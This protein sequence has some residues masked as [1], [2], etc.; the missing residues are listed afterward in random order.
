MYICVR[1]PAAPEADHHRTM[2]RP[3]SSPE[4]AG[5][6]QISGANTPYQ[7]YANDLSKQYSDSLILFLT[8]IRLFIHFIEILNLLRLLF[9]SKIIHFYCFIFSFKFIFICKF[10]SVLFLSLNR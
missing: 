4:V 10:K 7:S 5:H 6:Q 9:L 3:K 8:L 2:N 1:K